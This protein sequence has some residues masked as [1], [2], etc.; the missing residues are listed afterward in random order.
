MRTA[1]GNAKNAIGVLESSSNDLVSENEV[2]CA[3]VSRVDC[4]GVGVATAG[5][6]NKDTRMG[7]AA[8]LDASRVCCFGDVPSDGSSGVTWFVVPMKTRT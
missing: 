4:K 1:K 7:A 8:A 3:S 6:R 5:N 2:H